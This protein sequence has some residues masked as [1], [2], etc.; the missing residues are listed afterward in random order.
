MTESSI[1]HDFAY[2]SGGLATCDELAGPS[3]LGAAC[4][5]KDVLFATAQRGRQLPSS[6]KEGGGLRVSVADCAER[7]Q[8]YDIAG[9]I[10]AALA[11]NGSGNE[12]AGGTN[13]FRRYLR[14]PS[15]S[16][17]WA[18]VNIQRPKDVDPR[19][20]LLIVKACQVSPAA[21]QRS[22]FIRTA[23]CWITCLA[24][25]DYGHGCE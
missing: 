17:Q 18:G 21:V 4:A 12:K 3:A 16:L 2:R 13:A 11:L 5:S 15:A 19:M 6:A 20:L 24:G 7:C 8:A 10:S 1:L 9:G 25:C 22:P 14:P 23:E